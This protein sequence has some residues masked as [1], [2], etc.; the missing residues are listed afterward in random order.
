VGSLANISWYLIRRL[1]V[2]VA[3]SEKEHPGL[4]DAAM[5]YVGDVYALREM[6]DRVHVDGWGSRR[7]SCDSEDCSRL[8]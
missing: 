5:I 6:R 1:N 3:S 7:Y 2:L 8:P 4:P